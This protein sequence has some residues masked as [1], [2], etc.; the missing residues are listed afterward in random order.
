LRLT[1]IESGDV[2]GRAAAGSL[3]VGSGHSIAAGDAHS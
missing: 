3:F 1:D 2:R